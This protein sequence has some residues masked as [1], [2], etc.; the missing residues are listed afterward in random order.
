MKNRKFKALIHM[1]ASKFDV[2]VMDK[3]GNPVTFDLFKMDKNQRREFHREFLK[4]YR[5]QCV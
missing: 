2:T 4:A 5:Q 3:A 1:G